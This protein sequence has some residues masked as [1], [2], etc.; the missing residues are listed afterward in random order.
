MSRLTLLE[1][2]FRW[3]AYIT[4]GTLVPAVLRRDRN[5][6]RMVKLWPLIE[7]KPLGPLTDYDKTLHN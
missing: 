1:L 6:M 2:T 4:A 5:P 3:D 7:S